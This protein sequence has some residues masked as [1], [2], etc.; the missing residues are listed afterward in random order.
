MKITK[1]PAQHPTLAP[2]STY[3]SIEKKMPVSEPHCAGAVRDS[4]LGSSSITPSMK[5]GSSSR[6]GGAHM[7]GGRGKHYGD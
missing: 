3:Q 2:S 4:H 7:A 6:S 5:G 1:T